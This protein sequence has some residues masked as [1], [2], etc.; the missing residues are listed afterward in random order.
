MQR[1]GVTELHSE[2]DNIK[3]YQRKTAWEIFRFSTAA[4]IFYEVSSFLITDQFHLNLFLLVGS[5][6]FK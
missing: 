1:I 3:I 2:E 6:L 4:Q 5:E